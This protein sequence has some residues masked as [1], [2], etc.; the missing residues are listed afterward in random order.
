MEPST[1][2]TE[3]NSSR[4]LVPL[5]CRLRSR[6][7]VGPDERD[8]SGVVG[9][10]GRISRPRH[11]KLASAAGRLSRQIV[12][13]VRIGRNKLLRDNIQVVSKGDGDQWTKSRDNIIRAV[14]ASQPFDMLPDDDYSAWNDMEIEFVPTPPPAK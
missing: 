14:F 6:A 8:Q 7:F 9:L 2:A 4:D 11:A 5:C 3:S 13:N 10:A 1:D 12:I